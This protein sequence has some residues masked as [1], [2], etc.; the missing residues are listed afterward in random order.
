M[1][2]IITK[3]DLSQIDGTVDFGGL[4]FDLLNWQADLKDGD[5]YDSI[6]YNVLDDVIDV[7]I[8][9]TVFEGV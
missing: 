2:K 7:V 1:A 8:D 5:C 9:N 6:A 3:E 4:I